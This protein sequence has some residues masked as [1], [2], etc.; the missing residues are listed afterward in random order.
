M[1]L[2]SARVMLLNLSKTEAGGSSVMMYVVRPCLFSV[3]LSLGPS[4]PSSLFV[5][6]FLMR[7][8]S[9]DSTEGFGREVRVIFFSLDPVASMA[10]KLT[11]LFPGTGVQA[12]FE[13]SR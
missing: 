7:R 4:C 9:R 1:T 10:A 3:F 12:G 13:G 2:L 5:W 6:Q 8:L 11:A